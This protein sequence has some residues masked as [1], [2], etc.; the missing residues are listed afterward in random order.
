MYTH[1]MNLYIKRKQNITLNCSKLSHQLFI[2][3]VLDQLIKMVKKFWYAM[4]VID[5][6]FICVCHICIK[7]VST[8]VQC[9]FF[10]QIKNSQ[11]PFVILKSIFHHHL[12]SNFEKVILLFKINAST[13]IFRKFLTLLKSTTKSKM[14]RCLIIVPNTY[15]LSF[16]RS[17]R[18]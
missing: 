13:K 16:F 1:L 3:A 9:P 7:I 11:Q 6:I 17:L 8:I 5:V 18:Y 10:L 15:S 14:F 4:L 12:I 2:L